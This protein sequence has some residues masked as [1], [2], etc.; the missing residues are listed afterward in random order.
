M[1]DGSSCR[2]PTLLTGRPGHIVGCEVSW[3]TVVGV[4]PTV[5]PSQP[6]T[7]GSSVADVVVADRGSSRRRRRRRHLHRQR[8]HRH[9]HHRQRRMLLSDLDHRNRRMLEQK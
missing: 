6:R 9:H 8:L 1:R 3:V 5:P 4:Y 2:T 7:G